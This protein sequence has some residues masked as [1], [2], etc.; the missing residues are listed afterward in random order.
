MT[1]AAMDDARYIAIFR[2][3]S[4]GVSEAARSVDEQVKQLLEEALRS[5]SWRRKLADPLTELEE[6]YRESHALGQDEERTPPSVAALREAAT[7]IQSLPS[8]VPAPTS[9]MEPSGAIGL[10]WY[11]GPNKFLVFAVDGTGRVEYSAILGLGEEHHGVTNFRG[12]PPRHGLDLLAELLKGVAAT[13][14]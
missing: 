8:W 7:L 6:G 1:T 3:T 2:E 12:G 14:G 9:V 11:L 13:H 5:A 4:R 10:E